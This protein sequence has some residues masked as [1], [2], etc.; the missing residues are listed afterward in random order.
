MDAPFPEGMLEEIRTFLTTVH[1]SLPAGLD[2]Y[3]EMF[4]TSLFF[5]L[6][7]QEELAEMMRLARQLKPKVVMEIGADKGGGLYHW[8]KCL[9]TVTDVIACEI[10]G[11][12]YRDDFTE[13]FPHIWFWW[14]PHSSQNP[15][16][17]NLVR[18]VDSSSGPIDVLFIDGDKASMLQ[19]FD[20]YLPF[21]ASN[22]LVFMHDVTDSH[23][24]KEAFEAVKARGY[25]TNLIHSIQDYT[26]LV[27]D[28]RYE[29]KRQRTPHQNWLLHWQGRSC[30]VGVIHLDGMR[31]LPAR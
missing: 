29:G 24:P 17:L 10:R 15:K 13:A 23:G 19:D 5:P 7:R 28:T 25:R 30:G 14:A 11:T 12:P 2:L 31:H 6:Q 4:R 22:G 9:P 8:C 1:P 27:R 16:T 18:R 3:P 26:N 20:T 21:M